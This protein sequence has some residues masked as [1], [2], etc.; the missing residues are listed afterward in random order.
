MKYQTADELRASFLAFF[1]S[2]GHTVLPSASLVPVDDP[3]LLWINSGVATLKPYFSGQQ[4][5]PNP[6]LANS[7][8]S[9]RTNDIENVGRTARHHTLFEMLGN[10]S[11]GDYFKEDA[12]VWAYEYMTGIVGFSPESLWISVHPEDEEALSLWREKVGVPAERIVKLQD[13][14]WDIG[15]GPCGPNS[16]IYYDRGGK[17]ACE[18]PKCAPGCDCERYLEVWNLVFSQYNHHEDGTYT[19]LPRKNIDTG[20]G[21]ERLASVVQGADTN[22]GTDLFLPYIRHVEKLTGQS[23]S[24]HQMAINVIADHVRAITFA[25]AD[26]AV[27]ANEGRGYVIRRLLRRAVRFGGQLGLKSPFLCDMVPLVARVMSHAYPELSEK[28]DYVSRIVRR[29]EERFLE[30]LDLGTQLFLHLARELTVAGAKELSGEQAFRLYDT[31]GFPLDLTVDLAREHGLT[32]DSDGFAKAMEEQRQRA[33]FARPDVGSDFGK[34][35]YFAALPPTRFTGLE[36]TGGEATVVGLLVDGKPTEALSPGEGGAV[37]LDCTPFYAESGGQVGDRGHI[38]FKGGEFRVKD[39]QKYFGDFCLHVGE[40]T[41]GTLSLGDPVSADVDNTLRQALARAHTATH[42]LHAALRRVLGSH[43]RQAGSLVEPDRLRFDFSHFTALTQDE[44]TAIE[45]EINAHI[46]ASLPVES[47]HMTLEDARAGGATALFGE[48]YGSEVRVVSMG[49]VSS[50]LCGGTHLATT[51]AVGLCLL[52]GEGGIGAG[53]RRIEAVSGGEAYLY[54][55]GRLSLLDTLAHTLK[56]KPDEAQRRLESVLEQSKEAA[57][58]AERLHAKLA[59]LAAADFVAGADEVAGIKVVACQVQAKDVDALRAAADA[60]RDKLPSGVAVL[61]AVQ[62][63]KV[64]LIAM[65]SEDL[66]AHGLH[67]GNLIRE[68]AKLT[69]GGGG[70]KATVAQAGG[71]DPSRLPAALKAVVTLVEAQLRM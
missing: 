67:A 43:V 60:V 70:G 39:T 63:D 7:Q 8:K 41:H 69:G 33:R 6:R 57:K 40:L 21:L 12:I 34:V 10:F 3:T 42:L 58:E 27:P 14:F 61:G 49:E 29:E 53:L 28:Q 66:L 20:M 1:R 64:A 46:L 68:V 24:G 5:P 11:I 48:K 4:V 16:E 59:A 56:T 65:V 52:L 51:S 54:A 2:K 31:F 45:A 38:R 22:Y 26:G 71:K 50:E 15:P 30:T 37:L 23:Y 35:N 55:K 18:N 32:V 47:A 44:L 62:E 19:P 17:Y 36:G 25:V 9:I 13:N